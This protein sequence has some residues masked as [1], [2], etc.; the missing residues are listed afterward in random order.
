MG[1]QSNARCPPANGIDRLGQIT[2]LPWN[3]NSFQSCDLGAVRRDPRQRGGRQGWGALG[4]V[5]Q[6]V[7]VV[8]NLPA[9]DGDVRDAGSIPGSERSPGGGRDNALQYSCLK[10]PVDRGTWRATVHGVTK[11]QIRLKQPSTHTPLFCGEEG[12]EGSLSPRTRPRS[13]LT[14]PVRGAQCPSTGTQGGLSKVPP[15]C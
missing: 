6:M 2:K 8:K 9:N 5:Y 13:A 15:G 11:S 10:N 14:N 3:E 12:S 4:W 1:G 7:L